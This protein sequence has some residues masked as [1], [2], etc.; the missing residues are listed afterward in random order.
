VPALGN[1]KF[2]FKKSSNADLQIREYLKGIIGYT[3][4]NFQ[5]FKLAML[6]SSVAKKNIQGHPESNERLEYL[7]DAILGAVIA[8]Y[9][10]KKY[11]YKDEGFLT[12]IRS[13]IVSR[14]SLNQLGAKLGLQHIIEANLKVKSPYK[15][16]YGDTL[17]ALVGAVY[18]D[19]GYVYCRKFILSRLLEPYFNLEE[20]IQTNTNYKSRII[21]WSQKESKELNFE[22]INVKDIKNRKEFTVEVLIDHKPV[23][24]GYGATKKKAEQNAALKAIEQLNLET[25]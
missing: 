18:L 2:K 24:V 19:R 12:L 5:L 13:R 4:R 14:E 9:L 3:P 6:H 17:E 22:T 7:G 25:Y 8:E 15:S 11:P 16:V 20:L 10:F 23:A 1:F 21:E